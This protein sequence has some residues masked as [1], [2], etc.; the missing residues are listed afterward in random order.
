MLL[1]VAHPMQQRPLTQAAAS[2]P[3]PCRP[4]MLLPAAPPMQQGP[5]TL[6]LLL[7]LPQPRRATL[8]RQAALLLRAVGRAA[9]LQPRA[10][11]GKAR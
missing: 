10:G 1:P 11:M 9:L 3:E 4:S 7:L 2:S 5:R 8:L 6:L